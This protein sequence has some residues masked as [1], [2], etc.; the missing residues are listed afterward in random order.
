MATLSLFG[1]LAIA[2]CRESTGAG[3]DDHPQLNHD[4][5][6]FVHGYDGD[7]NTFDQMRARFEADGWRDGVE[8][9]AFRY[10]S[11]VT[12]AA[13]AQEIRNHVKFIMEKT[14]AGKVDIISHEMGSLSSRFY[15]R[16]FGGLEHV[17]A[18][19][20]LGG[21]NHGT[22]KSLPCTAIPC[23]EMEA[24]S[25]FITALNA[26]VEGPPPARYATWRSPCD[27]IV[28]PRESVSVWDAANFLTACLANKDL[29]KDPGVYE[30]V[31]GF[32][33]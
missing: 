12:N 26:D 11:R 4:P 24:E 23:Q 18:W 8:L 20:S 31:K 10:S 2:G 3:G 15:I 30:Q 32:V 33:E 6:L 17:D 14:G 22:T 29:V 19:V 1:L 25:S 5:I 7:E 27:E 13:N 16:H 21:P 9:F 28:E